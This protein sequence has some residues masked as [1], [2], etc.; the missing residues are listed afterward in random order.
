MCR[1]G[2]PGEQMG[3]FLTHM[4][5]LMRPQHLFGVVLQQ[6]LPQLQHSLAHASGPDACNAV[7]VLPK[8]G[9]IAGRALLE[10]AHSVLYVQVLVEPIYLEDLARPKECTLEL[11]VRLFRAASLPDALTLMSAGPTVLQTCAK[12]R[13]GQK[14]R[15]PPHVAGCHRR[16]RVPGRQPGH[17]ATG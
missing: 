12:V 13:K 16:Q 14:R 11:S 10:L 7:L 3:Y 2:T 1:T 8:Q 4:P 6:T 5:D 17:S 15:L 9:I